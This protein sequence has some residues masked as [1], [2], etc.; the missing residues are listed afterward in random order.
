[1]KRVTTFQGK[2]KLVARN[3]FHRNKEV[4]PLATVRKIY[5][6]KLKIVANDPPS[7]KKLRNTTLIQA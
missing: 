1:M 7:F 2:G 4:T 3:H 5:L 6:L